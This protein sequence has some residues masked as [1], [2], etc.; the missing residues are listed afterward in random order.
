[1]RLCRLTLYAGNALRAGI[2]AF[3][4]SSAIVFRRGRSTSDR[5]ETQRAVYL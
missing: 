1:V 2:C 4:V 3:G 5:R